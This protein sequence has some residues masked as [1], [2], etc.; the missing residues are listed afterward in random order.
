VTQRGELVRFDHNT[1]QL[2]AFL[3]GISA[4]SVAFSP[5]GKSV[6]YV[7]FPDGIL[8]KANRDGSGKVQLT[9]SSFRPASARWSPDGTQI[10][11]DMRNEQNLDSH[12]YVVP[13]QGGEARRL[14]TEEDR[15]Q[16]DGGWSSDG[17]KIVYSS[18]S[19]KSTKPE[20]D[21]RLRVLDLDSGRITDLPGSTGLFSPRWSPDGRSIAAMKVDSNTILVFNLETQKWSIVL[22][23]K[24]LGF[25][26]WSH[27]SLFIYTVSPFTGHAV[28]RV[29]ASGGNAERVLDLTGFRHTGTVDFW[30]GLD[31]DDVPLL[32]RDVGTDDL[33]ALTLEVK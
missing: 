3:G 1:H 28:F 12:L 11:F 21:W 18:I 10:L 6:A 8:W 22:E 33:Y 16:F 4:E 27:D 5:D 29:R 14:P 25:P 7:T 9:N 30:M 2:Q 32:L 17:R 24:D 19:R 31:P 23:Q 15:S 20:D 13:S 26:T